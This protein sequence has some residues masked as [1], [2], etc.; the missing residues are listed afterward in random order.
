MMHMKGLSSQ[1]IALAKKELYSALNSPATYGVWAFFLLFNSITFFYLQ[2][3]FS[4]DSATLRPYFSVIPL[5]YTL[6]IPAITMKSWAEERKTGTA[7]LLLTMPFS[8]WDLVLGKFLSS[9]M[10]LVI[11]LVLTLGVPFSLF[12]LG[13]FDGGVIISEY[14]GALLLGMAAVAL[15]QLFSSLAKNQISA[16]LG[17]VVVLLAVM[18]LNQLTSLMDLPKILADI[19]NYL[20]LAFHFESFARGILD[21]RDIL[22]FILVTLLFLFI[23]TR[24]L[25]FRKWS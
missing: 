15:G 11:A 20:S 12:P 2:K 14:I 9:L 10:I 4:L 21:S 17:G 18:L 3:F 23:N 8:E 13:D 5:V 25:L 22:F 19:L 1:S 16:F 6:L 24:V 7:E